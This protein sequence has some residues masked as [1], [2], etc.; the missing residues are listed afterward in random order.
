MPSTRQTWRCLAVGMTLCALGAG[1]L[2]QTCGPQWLAGEGVPGTNQGILASVVWDPDGEGPETP[3]VA[4]G[5]A[6]TIAG[7]TLANYVATYDPQ[8]GEW[9]RLGNGFNSMV[10]SLAVLPEGGLVAGGTF[11]QADGQTARRVARW[12]GS[13]W[14]A[15][16]QGFD[17][18]VS[19]VTVRP[20]G[21]VIAAGAFTHSGATAINRIARWDGAA[22]QGLG[23]G[24][25]APDGLGVFA[26]SSLD[27]G[28]LVAGG[29][30]TNAG[31]L[32]AAN[33]ARWD[34]AWHAMAAGFDS[35]VR[36]FTHWDSDGAGPLPVRLV[37]AGNFTARAA[38]WSGS[39]WLNLTGL[40]VIDALGTTAGGQL[41]AGSGL[42]NNGVYVRTGSTWQVLGGGA[43][44]VAT[45]FAALPDGRLFVGGGS[46]YLVNS[47]ATPTSNVGLWDGTSWTV[48]GS[49]FNH[50]VWSLAPTPGG[51]LI[52][53]GW[54]T[55][56]DEQQR[57]DMVAR[58]DGTRWSP[59]GTGPY[60]PGAGVFEVFA[61]QNGEVFA[62]GSFTR[63]GGT[64]ANNIAR[65]SGSAWVAMGTGI[66]TGGVNT[67]AQ[68]PNGNVVVGGNFTSAGGVP[69]VSLAVW[70]G[71]VWSAFGGSERAVQDMVVTASGEFFTVNEPAPGSTTMFVRRWNG[72]AWE[73][74]GTAF[75][76]TSLQYLGAIAA[77][78][79]GGVVVGGRFTSSADGPMTNIAYWNG[80]QW[81]ALGA[82]V[83]DPVV[84][85]AVLEDGSIVALGRPTSGTSRAWRWNGSLWSDM[86]VMASNLQGPRTFAAIPG[87]LAIGGDFVGAAGKVSAYFARWSLT[88]APGAAFDPVDT[89]VNAG[90][91]VTLSATPEAGFEGVGVQWLRNGKPISD[92]AGGASPGGG[93]VSGASHALESPTDGT[94]AELVIDG[95]QPSDAGEYAAVFSNT[96]GGSTTAAA[97]VTV[98]GPACPTDIDGNGVVN[99]TDVG[100]FINAW[101][102]DQVKGTLVADWDGNGIVNSTD[103][104]EFIN[105]WFEDIAAGCG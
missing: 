33:V 88:G 24:I 37:A 35:N 49:G 73:N 61:T 8:T 83:S 11:T 105:S 2:G 60:A 50:E 31:G 53:G 39:A 94:P 43:K 41:V 34:G 4:V 23:T 6:F 72:S 68:L 97:S 66:T 90:E 44:G 55:G 65:W 91:T 77:L 80:T 15:M 30:F 92:G 5:G 104:G 42:N 78:P 51:G 64:L 40:S 62:A 81:A 82:G 29:E 13:G 20:N 84:D 12:N 86:G 10:L 48:P 16:G 69:A 28:D 59:M 103:V 95:V 54:F 21:D 71:S 7:T 85:I 45:S 47:S 22:W 87:G 74:F 70:N 63:I 1:A 100:E 27:N 58:W 18:N 99:S 14:V 75:N 67:F 52:A 19:A 46:F 36:A 101:F 93:T 96:C 17:A 3:K 38:I 25:I 79:G 98:K 9:S 56:V 89:T 32:A 102:L 76:R 26:L 57:T